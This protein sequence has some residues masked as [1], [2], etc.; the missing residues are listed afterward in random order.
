MPA[1]PAIWQAEAGGQ[2]PGQP[3][4]FNET[5]SQNKKGWRCSSVV[6]CLPSVTLALGLIASTEGV[7][8]R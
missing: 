7:K 1:I 4:K 2:I 5:L 6:E 8:K 3:G